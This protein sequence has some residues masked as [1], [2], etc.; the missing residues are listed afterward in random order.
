M[1]R[2]RTAARAKPERRV[3]VVREVAM[4]PPSEAASTAHSCG[5]NGALTRPD[6]DYPSADNPV[7]TVGDA[8]IQDP[9][10][11]RGPRRGDAAA[12]RRSEPA[13]TPDFAPATGK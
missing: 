11:P 1:A 10:S 12:A 9:R 13:R 6:R 4:Q 5:P 3:E 8:G 7:T 2:M